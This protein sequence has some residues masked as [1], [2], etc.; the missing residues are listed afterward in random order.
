MRF[1]INI[2]FLIKTTL[3]KLQGCYQ[4]CCLAPGPALLS[5]HRSLQQL[6]HQCEK[7]WGRG[8]RARER[9]LALVLLT[10]KISNALR[11]SG[12]FSRPSGCK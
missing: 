4:S 2:T 5:S 6:C 3:Q 11:A 8:E 10:I 7:G 1:C 12:S 9:S